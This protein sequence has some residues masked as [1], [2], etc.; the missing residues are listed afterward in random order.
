MFQRDTEVRPALVQGCLTGFPVA[1]NEF[2]GLQGVQDADDFFDV[3]ADAQIVH[4]GVTQDPLG[5]DQ[6]DASIGQSLGR[7]KDFVRC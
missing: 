1:W 6:E 5:V 3:S 4:G 2:V 7:I